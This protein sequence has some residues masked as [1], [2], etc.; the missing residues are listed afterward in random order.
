MS[1]LKLI[2][3]FERWL[4]KNLK[5]FKYKPHRVDY[6]QYKFEGIANNIILY[7]NNHTTE[8]ELQ[9]LDKDNNLIDIIFSQYIS[10]S[11]YIKTKGYT[12]I[13]WRNKHKNTFYHTYINMIIS[14]LFDRLVSY[15]NEFFTTENYLYIF[16]DKNISEAIIGNI[17]NSKKIKRLEMNISMCR[18]NLIT[19]NL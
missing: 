15:C 5:K 16:N 10:R 12:D 19:K 8:L 3:Y 18:F 1:T 6:C 14:E 11:K 17:D 2:K 4:S 13:N 7:V 9:V